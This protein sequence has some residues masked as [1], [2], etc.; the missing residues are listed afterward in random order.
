MKIAIIQTATLLGHPEKNR[1]T[2][3][4]YVQQA[5]KEKIDTVIFPE[6]WNVGFFPENIEEIVEDVKKSESLKWMQEVA[7]SYQINIV[8]GSI[9]IKEGEKLLNRCYV[10]NRQGEVVYYYDKAHLFSPGREPSYFTAGEQNKLFELD[11]I[12]CAV[13]ICY[14]IRFPELARKQ[15]LAGAK[16]LFV[17]AQWPHPRSNHWVALSKARAI[18]N[19]LYV[20]TCNGCGVAG[21]I[22]SCGNSGLYD[23]WGEELI[24]AGEEEGIHVASIDIPL[25]EEVRSKI[26]V[27]Q[28]RLP[29]LYGK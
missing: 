12:P 14:D 19:Q 23:P 6:T 26:P 20:V 21:K 5:V 11:G 10:I 9:A 17:P 25:V 2:L 3:F 8:G 4:T 29:L 22:V 24:L 1:E 28:D 16:L 13:Q 18:E 7:T 15:A 27:F